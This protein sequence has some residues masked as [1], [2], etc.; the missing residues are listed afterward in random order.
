MKI[1]HIKVWQIGSLIHQLTGWTIIY[2]LLETW[3]SL[4]LVKS[5]SDVVKWKWL[6]NVCARSFSKIKC[7]NQFPIH[8]V[9]KIN[10]FSKKINEFPSI[11][12]EL[13]SF[14]NEPWTYAINATLII[15]RIITSKAILLLYLRFLK[16]LHQNKLFKLLSLWM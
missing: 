2:N 12:C 13:N 11:F 8:S 9:N 4:N 15:I 7:I 10:I 14:K 16:L 1:N 3:S 5:D 6:M